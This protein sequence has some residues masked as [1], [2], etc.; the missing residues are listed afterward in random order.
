[1]DFKYISMLR[2]DNDATNLPQVRGSGEE[3]FRYFVENRL[4]YCD[5]KWY[6]SDYANDYISLR[7][8]TPNTWAGIT[9]NPAITVTPFSDMYAGVRYKANGTLYQERATHGVPVA[10][11][12]QGE[13]FESENNET[14]NDTE[15][16]VYGAHQLSSIGDL[17][18]LYCGSVNVS[19]A[20]KLIELKVGDGT[21]GYS[22]ANLRELSVGTNK[23]LKKIDVQNCPNFTSVLDLSNCPSIEEVYAKGSGITGVNFAAAGIL[24]IAQLPGTVTNITLKNQL[25]IETFTLESYSNVKT[26]WIENCPTLNVQTLLASCTNVERVRLTDV[27][28]TYD[29]AAEMKALAEKGL[30]GIDENGANIDQMW[31]DGKCHIKALTGTEYLAIKEA[32]P[33]VEITYD[34]LTSAL[35]FMSEDGTTELARQTIQNGGDGEYTGTTPTKESTAQYHFT[36]A[37]WSLTPGGATDPNALKAVTADRMVYATFTGTLRSYTVRFYNGSTLL[38]AYTVQYGGT[39]TYAGSTPVNNSTGN[40]DDFEFS[41]WKPSPTN[42]QGDTNCYAQFYDMREITDSWATIAENVANG[43]AVDK[44]AIGAFK[45]LDI[46]A[47]PLPYDFE[48]GAAVIYNDEVHI[49]GTITSDYKKA[50]YKW[51]GS[52]WVEVSTL[53]YDFAQGAA[54]VYNNEIHII[55]SNASSLCRTKHYKWNGSTWTE[56]SE[57]PYSFANGS[58]IVYNNEIHIL[59]SSKSYTTHH[60]WNGSVWTEVSTLPYD[61]YAGSVVVYNGELHLLGSSDYGKKHYKYDGSAWASVS[62]IPYNFSYGSAFVYNTEIRLLGGTDSKTNH[63]KWNGTAW[64]EVEELPYSFDFGCSV[65]TDTE[66]Y[67]MGGSND[68]TA[69]CQYSFEE[70]KWSKVGVTDSIPM[71]VVAHNHDELAADH[72]W[73]SL[74]DLP[75]MFYRASC[76]NLNGEIHIMGSGYGTHSKKHYKWDGSSWTSV[77]TLPYSF[78]YGSAVV[79]N[80]EIHIL[81]CSDAD[82]SHYKW[83]GTEWVSVSTLPYNFYRGVA[84]VFNN[85]IHIMGSANT[86]Y[87]LVHYKWDGSAWTSVGAPPYGVQDTAAVV[88]NNEIHI[89]GSYMSGS[90]TAHYKYDGSTWTEV[91]T[92]P[93]DFYNG[94]AVVLGNE[95]HIL[96]TNSTVE[97]RTN[98]YKWSGT[99]W[100]SVSTLPFGFYD[101]CIVVYDGKITIVGSYEPGYNKKFAR[102]AGPSW[103]T[104]DIPKPLTSNKGRVYSCN[105]ELHFIFVGASSNGHYKWNET[106]SEWVN[107]GVLPYDNCYHTIVYNNEIHIL[108]SSNSSYG[109]YHYKWNATDGWVSVSTLPYNAYNGVTVVY[110]GALHLMGGTSTSSSGDQYH[111]KW[112][113]T[114]WTEVST[115]PYKFLE[116]SAVEYNN[117]LHILGGRYKVNYHYKWDGS[118]WTEVSTS[119]VGYSAKAITI[120]NELHTFGGSQDSY[121]HHKWSESQGWIELSPLPLTTQYNNVF[122]HRCKVW[123]G[124]LYTLSN[125]KATLTFVAGNLLSERY[126]INSTNTNKGG[127]AA[128]DVRSYL[129]G[130]FITKLPTDLQGSVTEVLKISDGGYD[131]RTLKQTSD[132]VWILSPDE[133]GDTNDSGYILGQG[134]TY[135]VFTDNQSRR[136]KRLDGSG[137]AYCLRSTSRS[138]GW[139]YNISTSGYLSTTTPNMN[140]YHL[141]GFCI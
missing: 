103:E 82:T 21:E 129:N 32:F 59:G 61:Y 118:T 77:S 112:D 6:A 24:R 133:V 81:G 53:P 84:V 111:Y 100:V 25:A 45:Q 105:N 42:I 14:F 46:G 89:L 136:R 58:A 137:S 52:E 19:N 65:I 91:S 13:T 70:S 99:E 4:N 11:T 62:T 108:S 67:L 55:G 109:T 86:Q 141:I 135:G 2:S 106:N 64:V 50:H 56:V 28:W 93:Y 20:D 73:E 132:K 123:Q 88:L 31:I 95:I 8:Y 92:I 26:L 49:L 15:T 140:P 110:D 122:I 47:T 12:P 98:H 18:A 27:D 76:V 17:A 134:S 39:A 113:G 1:M 44:Y 125:P 51:T 85:E 33:Y 43:T 87:R 16:A 63:Y 124:Y 40:P 74:A 97:G 127:W 120:N 54:V 35:I 121:S 107:I 119:P 22:N 117:E 104:T 71:Q 69:F 36:H 102:L 130:D 68:G 7:I 83:N 101:G 10:F 114:S 38:E 94:S 138:E 37:G 96:G 41:G 30:A 57:L 66:I 75:H 90:R 128:S 48:C 3:H 78:D 5:S 115:L 29:T 9:P 23:L 131:N 139:W 60:K 79:Y 116:G 80:D 72:K 126:P 34:T